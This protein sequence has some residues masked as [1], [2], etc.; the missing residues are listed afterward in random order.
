MG[1][2]FLRCNLLTIT[3]GR[4]WLGSLL[5][6][7]EICQHGTRPRNNR[8]SRRV[9]DNCP[10]CEGSASDWPVLPAS[11]VIPSTRSGRSLPS[12]HRPSQGTVRCLVPIR[13]NY[14]ASRSDGVD[15]VIYYNSISLYGVNCLVIVRC[16]LVFF[17]FYPP[18][19]PEP[20]LCR[21]L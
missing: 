21:S 14:P 8:F 15:L 16:L 18:P 6:N 17:S 3:I 10:T 9:V 12:S 2:R 13:P 1:R 4:R 7:P 5:L 11:D 19:L 20:Q